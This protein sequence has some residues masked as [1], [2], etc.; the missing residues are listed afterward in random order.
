VQQGSDTLRLRPAAAVVSELAPFRLPFDAVGEV[1]G[2]AGFVGGRD[3]TGFFDAQATATRAVLN[4]GSEAE[5]DIGAG[6]WTARIF[7][8]RRYAPLWC[9]YM[10]ILVAP[11]WRVHP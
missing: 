2:Q 1:Y 4:L 3:A 9:V 7:A 6:L 10:A 5:L 8:N 11:E